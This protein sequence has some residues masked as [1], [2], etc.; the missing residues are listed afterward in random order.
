MRCNIP[1]KMCIRDRSIDNNS[2][3]ICLQRFYKR[4]TTKKRHRQNN[5]IKMYKGRE[6]NTA[7]SS[8]FPL[9]LYSNDTGRYQA[10]HRMQ[11]RLD[12]IYRLMFHATTYNTQ[13]RT[14][15][16]TWSSLPYIIDSSNNKIIAVIIVKNTSIVWGRQSRQYNIINKYIY[17]YIP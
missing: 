6:H 2:R 10:V 8:S 11:T 5:N 15:T 12:F 14:K 16:S 7:A 13:T 9:A 4:H 3:V 17:N 1:T